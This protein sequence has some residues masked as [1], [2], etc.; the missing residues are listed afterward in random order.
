MHH[1]GE[2]KLYSTSRLDVTVYIYVKQDLLFQLMD[3][4]VQ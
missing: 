2:N 3:E 4:Y 1:L